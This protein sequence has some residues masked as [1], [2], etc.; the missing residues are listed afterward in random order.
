MAE[1]KLR[2]VILEW[3]KEKATQ[4]EIVFDEKTDAFCCKKFIRYRTNDTTALIH[5]LE[6][7]ISTWGGPYHYFYEIDLQNKTILRLQLSFCYK[8]I[9]DQSKEICEE[10]LRKYKIDSRKE[11]ESNRGFFRWVCKYDENIDVGL[12]EEEIKRKMDQLFYQMKGYEAFLISIT[13]QKRP[14]VSEQTWA[15]REEACNAVNIT[16][17]DKLMM[18]FPYG[19]YDRSINSRDD[20]FSIVS[21]S[22]YKDM[23]PRH[24]KGIGNYKNEKAEIFNYITDQI[25]DYFSQPAMHKDEF[26]HWHKVLCEEI[27]RRFSTLP[28]IELKFGKAQKL[29]NITF[30]CLYCFID[31]DSKTEHF[32]YC[33]IPIDSNVIKWCAKNAGIKRPSTAWSSMEYNDYQEFEESLYLWLNSKENTDCRD[34]DGTPYSLLQ[35]DFE[36]WIS[37]TNARNGIVEKWKSIRKDSKLWERYSET[38]VS[39]F[40]ELGQ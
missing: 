19:F 24:L 3:A 12:T 35:L 13:R 40:S 7:G 6:G 4:G 17:R 34:D 14:A 5:D 27:C 26:D 25:V 32:K 38:V 39:E 9:S 33:H 15:D 11:N 36:A 37:D 21:G 2:N 31:A 28:N 16:L 20:I 23:T 1:K 10:I 29:V 18:Y 30:K 8:N 22:A